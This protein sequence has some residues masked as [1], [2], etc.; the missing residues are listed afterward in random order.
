MSFR[1]VHLFPQ[2]FFVFSY[3][4]TVKAVLR[5]LSCLLL[6]F[7]LTVCV[8][9]A[10]V[11]SAYSALTM[12]IGKDTSISPLSIP[13][14]TVKISVFAS[15]NFS[16]VLTARA[17][18]GV[19]TITNAKPAG[20][21]TITVMA[22][23]SSGNST[24][25]SFNLT[26]NNTECSDGRFNGNTTVPVLRPNLTGLAIGDF[27]GDGNQ[28]IAAAHVGYNSVEV[29]LGNG[30]GGFSPASEIGATSHPY[31]LVIGDFDRDGKQDMAIACEGANLVAIRMGDGNGGFSVNSNV[32]VGQSPIGI[33]LG[34]FN[35]DGKQDIVTA[36]YID[37]NL[38]IRLGDG[39][40]GFT[41]AASVSVGSYP[42]SVAVGDFNSDGKQD[43]AI[44]NRGSDNVSIR[45]GNGLGGFSV[46]PNIPVGY[47]PSSIVIDDFN[48]DGHQ[49]FAVSNHASNSISVRYGNGTGT[50]TGNTEIPV[51]HGPYCLASGNFN[52]DDFTD[53]VVTNYFG[54]TVSARFGDGA[55]G[56][57]GTALFPVGTYPTGIAVG[58]FNNDKRMDLAIANYYDHTISVRYGMNGIPSPNPLSSNSPVCDGQRLRLYSYGGKSYSWSGPGGFSSTLQNPEIN[59]V[60]LSHHGVFALTMTDMNNCIATSTTMIN[61]N[62]LPVVSFTLPTDSLCVF[63]HAMPLSGGL[64]AGGVYLGPGVTNSSFN[65]GVAGAGSHYLYYSFTDSN[66]CTNSATDKMTVLICA[67][68]PEISNENIF[69][70]YPNPVN[71]SFTVEAGEIIG[72]GCHLTLLNTD[73]SVIAEWEFTGK[74]RQE[75]SLEDFQSGLYVLRLS[76]N[77]TQ[78][79]TRIIKLE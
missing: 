38:S 40:G 79:F 22:F 10:Q 39:A 7:Y 56:F 21:Y 4:R 60:S 25:Q 54:N 74:N 20:N 3:S 44:A 77:E 62:P 24:S 75:F 35:N 2:Y 65:P 34:D 46:K 17:S 57:T 12:T 19:I 37:H 5:T 66:E 78:G 14:N 41:S 67:A 36:N 6:I 68:T 11:L 43:L 29:S 76:G 51:G 8:S 16:G 53:L 45:M 18:T 42:E 33:A 48:R 9:S 13:S 61:V 28:D 59:P 52:G 69:S 73:G 70:V 58:E 1:S 50:F 49:D 63:D 27:N 47:S 32:P 64:P 30:S 71:K 26:V 15:G 31:A 23:S 72:P 55:G